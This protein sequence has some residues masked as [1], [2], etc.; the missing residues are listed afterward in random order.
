MSERA[1]PRNTHWLRGLLVDLSIM[2]AIGL[3]L[4]LIGPFGSFEV[5]FAWRLVSWLSLA[6]I[7]YFIYSPLGS[8]ITRLGERLDLPRWGLWIFV[9][10]VATI[11]MTAVVWSVGFLP[12]PVPMPG[13]E[14]AVTLY[15]YVLVIGSGITLLFNLIQRK[16]RQPQVAVVLQDMAT[17]PAVRFLD[18]L[19][20]ALGTRLI[21][22][23]MEDHYVRAHTALGSELVLLRMRD[24]VAELDGI[25]GAQVHRSWWVA[26]DAVEDVKRD[27][28]SIRLV[29]NGG[30]Q[31]PIAR[32]RMQDLKEAGWI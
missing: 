29:L 20:P 19:S 28:R 12:R 10:L 11:P 5:P 30:L 31:A 21:A 13:L 6:W 8:L 7:G 15:F 27:G 2:T 9:C 4:A 1:L 14:Q 17:S 26:R 23:E 3:V 22:L 24:A 25:D 32:A 18:R 16:D